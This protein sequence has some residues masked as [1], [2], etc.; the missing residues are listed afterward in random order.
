MN[1]ALPRAGRP[2][3]P[4]KPDERTLSRTPTRRP[5][6]IDAPT[7]DVGHDAAGDTYLYAPDGTPVMQVMTV[8][9]GHPI[10]N[11]H[12]IAERVARAYNAAQAAETEVHH[13]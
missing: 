13:G 6:R 4:D 3:D 2:F 11:A 5:M 8:V 10:T 7:L 9:G 1:Q 12:A